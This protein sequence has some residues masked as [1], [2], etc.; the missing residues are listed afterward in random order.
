MKILE[1]RTKDQ[2]PR[3]KDSN[4]LVQNQNRKLRREKDLNPSHKDSKPLAGKIKNKAKD[5]NPRKKDPN[6]FYLKIA[7]D[8][9]LSRG[10][11]TFKGETF[12][13]SMG[14]EFSSFRFESLSLQVHIQVR[15]TSFNRFRK[16][17]LLLLQWP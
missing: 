17:S 14:S 6:P 13:C 2:N 1:T 3:Q 9:R 8:S 5:P 11:E 16:P 4:L 15:M 12:K 10:F 7:T